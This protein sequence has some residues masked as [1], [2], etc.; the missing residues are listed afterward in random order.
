MATEVRETATA[1]PPL[2]HGD[3]LTRAEFERRWAA[4]PDLKNAELINGRVYLMPPV[5]RSHG[6]PHFDLNG[7]LYMY[8][9]VTPG[10][11]GADNT[12]VRFDDD[13][14]P[15]PDGLLR[16]TRG[17][18]SNLDDDDI[19]SGPPEL[20]AEVSRSS[21]GYDLGEKKA[22]YRAKGVKEYVVWRVDDGVVDWFAL[23]PTGY[24]LLPVGAD[25]IVR[26]EVFPGLWLDP[27]ALVTDDR[28]AMVRAAQLGHGSPEHAAFVRRLA[29]TA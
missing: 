20:A 13:N 4:M 27:A 28:T 23:R 26:S 29:A 19:Y 9:M 2:R 5:S 8:Q 16:V 1:V 17:G 10:V 3:R 24:E 12:S 6:H 15:Q 7:W 11:E 18:R 14:M 22:L 21:A 25:G